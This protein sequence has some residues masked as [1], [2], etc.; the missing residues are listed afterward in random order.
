MEES[1]FE[2]TLNF[3][4]VMLDTYYR[5]SKSTT[6]PRVREEI[7]DKLFSNY[8][9]KVIKEKKASIFDSIDVNQF[10]STLSKVEGATI[11]KNELKI[12]LA[13]NIKEESFKHNQVSELLNDDNFKEYKSRIANA[14]PKLFNDSYYNK[15]KRNSNQKY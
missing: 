10:N 15:I 11:D 1:Q 7:E 8:A 5:Q 6:K 2:K 9:K 14:K 3:K 4:E 13:K 12:N